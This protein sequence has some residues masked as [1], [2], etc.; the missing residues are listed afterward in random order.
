MSYVS[1]SGDEYFII[2]PTSEITFSNANPRT[3]SP[4]D[5]GGDFKVAGFN[6]L[7]Y[8]IIPLFHYFT[9]LNVSENTCGPNNL[10]C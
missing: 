7:N 1:I 8:S 6:V 4:A 9:I 5:L 3:E 10:S 2:Q